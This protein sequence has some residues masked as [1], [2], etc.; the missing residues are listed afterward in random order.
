MN[1]R[2]FLYLDPTGRKVK[3]VKIDCD[4]IEV[5]SEFCLT[6]NTVRIIEMATDNVRN[7]VLL[8]TE[9]LVDE[10]QP[11][12]KSMNI[13]DMTLKKVVVEVAVSNPVIVGRLE[14]GLFAL[15]DGHIY[16]C[17]SVLKLRMDLV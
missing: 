8:M 14:S 5:T 7:Q 15:I 10:N 11:S 17:N 2:Q 16:F 3:K 13:F 4:D 6:L 9:V 12:I 1:P